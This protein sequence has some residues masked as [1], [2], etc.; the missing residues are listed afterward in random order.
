MD[1]QLQIPIRYAAYDW[2]LQ[3]GGDVG[4]DEL[5]EEYTYV[6]IKTNIGLEDGDFDPA[7]KEYNMQ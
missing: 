4:E 1:D 2:P 3:P 5:I 6:N 7:N